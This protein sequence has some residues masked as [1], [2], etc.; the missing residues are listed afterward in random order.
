MR[1]KFKILKFK[2]ILLINI[3]QNQYCKTLKKFNYECDEQSLFIE[4]FLN[5]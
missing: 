2:S 1:K 4:M 5:K 3:L